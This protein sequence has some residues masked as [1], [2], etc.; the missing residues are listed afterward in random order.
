M[1][2]KIWFHKKDISVLVVSDFVKKDLAYK[3]SWHQMGKINHH[4]II[5]APS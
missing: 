5:A 1:G 4:F 2:T 3:L